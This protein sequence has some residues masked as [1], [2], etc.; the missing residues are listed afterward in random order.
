MSNQNARLHYL[1]GQFA[2]NACTREELEELYALVRQSPD[3]QLHPL[4]DEQ[5]AQIK[6][7]A[8]AEKIDWESMYT[9]IVQS[10]GH[11]ARP[12]TRRLF[13][14]PKVAAA[15][16][17]LLALGV[18]AFWL[19]NHRATKDIDPPAGQPPAQADILPGGNK[20]VLTLAD[21]SQ[22]M[23]D[24]AA[25]GNI[26]RQGAV[27]VLKK[28]NG[29]LDYRLNDAKHA[30]TNGALLYNTLSTPRGGQYKLTLPDGT[31]VWL[32]AASSIRYPAVFDREKRQVEVTGEAYFEVA[33]EKD[34]KFIVRTEGSA[35]EVLGTHFNVNAYANEPS[36]NTTLVEGSVKVSR[37]NAGQNSVT[38]K[39]GQQAAISHS[40]QGSPQTPV[41]AILVQTVDTDPVIAWTKNNFTFTNISLANAMRQVE[42]WYDV[43]IVFRDDVANEQIMANI[44][45]D[46]P[47]SRLMYKLS[48]TGNLH[49]TIDNKTITVTR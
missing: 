40:S 27:E 17:I 14:F 18:G 29:A 6:A 49:F 46:V 2:I 15:A 45:R 16:A 48:L 37:G 38:L 44:S 7:G 12:V 22:I 34:R 41:Q 5:F 24:S 36:I 31:K 20:A 23:L 42:R 21:G 35:I 9:Q 3:H 13:S 4:M 43:K 19:F 25:N 30:T 39:P 28:D 26:A 10:M 8:E 1:F 47:I 11:P 32:N 33:R